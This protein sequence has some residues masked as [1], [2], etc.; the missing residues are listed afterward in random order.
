MWVNTLRKKLVKQV[1]NNNS[2]VFFMSV[3]QI[4]RKAITRERHRRLRRRLS[5]SALVPR[6]AVYRSNQHIYVQLINDLSGTTLTSASTVE[7]ALR[8]GSGANVA[9]A[10]A[11]GKLVGERAKALGI[12]RIVF[13]RGG[14]LYHGRIK[15]LADAARAT[16]L[17]F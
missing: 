5:G 8:S 6:L 14:N 12:E 3:R 15:A 4:N 1:K 9:A 2:R 7:K 13:D 10:E 11:V 16:G 17:V